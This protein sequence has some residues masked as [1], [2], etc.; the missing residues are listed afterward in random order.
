MDSVHSSSIETESTAHEGIAV[1]GIGCRFPGRVSDVG[2]FWQ[3]LLGEQDAVREVPENRWSGAAFYDRDAARPGHLRTRAGGYLEDV[4]S[5]DAHFFGITPHEAARIDPQQR[6]FLETTWEALQ[7]AGIVPESIA[8][9]KTAVYAG[10]SGHDYG[11][12]Q[13][14]PENRYLIGGH[15]M[16]GVT[17]CIVANRVS[18]LLDLRGP[19]MTV[20]TA[21]SSS[22]IAIHLACRSIRSGE[23]SM[24]IVGGVSTLLIPEA[25][26]G[27]SQGTFLSPEGRSKSF[28]E[29]ADGYVR[30]EGSGT[31]ILKPLSAALADGDRV[32]AVIRGSATNQ[33]G[34]TNGISVPS[35]E[36]QAQMIADACRDAG[37][38]PADIGYVEAH[39]TGTSVGDPIEARALGKALAPGRNGHGPCIVGA[40]KSNLGHLESAAGIAGVIKACLVLTNGEIPANLHAEVPNSTIPF[41]ELGLQLAQSRQPWPGDPPR[42]GGRNSIGVGG[43]HY[44]GKQTG[45]PAR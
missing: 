27:F 8:G 32:Y 29:S 7:D 20:D 40:V 9:T 45:P 6:L 34:R 22:L 19:S 2:D 23:A 26:I 35:E 17:N 25:T 4:T 42:R 10:V 41:D 3:L 38:A 18:Y 14:N 43:A 30:S 12:I 16:T 24:A 13:L 1:V 31:I 39:G 15:T 37:V 33:D 44:P 21:C 36:A 5:F 28:S 11:I